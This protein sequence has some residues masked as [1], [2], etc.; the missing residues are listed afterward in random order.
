M[1]PTLTIYT[2]S[3]S[4]T[5]LNAI[6]NG[7]AAICNQSNYIWGFA[8]MAALFHLV[9]APMVTAIQGPSGHGG[10]VLTKAVTSPFVALLLA[11]LLTTPSLKGPVQI[12]STIN[13]KTAVVNN[14]PVVISIMPAAASLL[15][16]DLGTLVST[17]YQSAGTNY[18]ALSSQMNGFVNPLKALLGA[19]YVVMGLGHIDS[20]V[21]TVIDACLGS[22][23]GVDYASV[24]Q[25]VMN[26]GNTTGATAAQTTSI[27]GIQGTALGALMY[28]AS[29][30]AYGQVNNLDPNQ[31]IIYSCPDAVTKVNNDINTDL[32]SA[33]FSRAVQIGVNSMDQPLSTADF[34]LN[35]L[36]TQYNAL[37]NADSV[38]TANVYGAVQAQQEL[39][40][41]MFSSL[42][43]TDLSCLQANGSDKTTCYATMEQVQ[44]TER[45]N[46][47]AAAAETP[48][49]KYAGNLANY[50]LALIIGLGPILVLFM[51]L[52]GVDA[53]K[54]AKMAV[55]IMVWPLLV[56]NVGAE[57]INGMICIQLSDFYITL[58]Q[59]GVISQAETYTAYQELS[60][61]IGAAS[62]LMASLP[63]LMSMIFGLSATA[64]LVSVA[65]KNTPDFGKSAADLAPAPSVT[66]GHS[67]ASYDM[68]PDGSA[69]FSTT[70]S[71]R[72]IA[73]T[74]ELS[75]MQTAGS[76]LSSART[77]QHTVSEAKT[78]LAAWREAFTSGHYKG[79]TSDDSVGNE[80]RNAFNDLQRV[81]TNTT[82][83][84]QQQS[85][86]ANTNQSSA[87]AG[88]QGGL[89]VSTKPEGTGASA[90]GSVS[91]TTSTGASDSF[92]TTQNSARTQD[93]NQSR[94]LSTAIAKVMA[95]HTTSRS[96]QETRQELQRSMDIQSSYQDLMSK[97]D[98]NTSSA[99]AAV[100][101]S[102][103]FIQFQQ[104]IDPTTVSTQLA[105]NREFSAYETTAGMRFDADPSNR[106]YLNQAEQQINA[107]ETDTILGNDRAKHV[108]ARMRAATLLANDQKAPSEKRLA[109]LEYLVG[110][111]NAMFGRQVLTAKRPDAV[112]KFKDLH[113]PQD[114]TG[115]PKQPPAQPGHHKHHKGKDFHNTHVGTRVHHTPPIPHVGDNQK[116]LNAAGKALASDA[117]NITKTEVKQEIAASNAGL[118]QD[119]HGTARRTLNNA[120][121]NLHHQKGSG[122]NNEGKKVD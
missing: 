104:H 92:Q 80:I 8:V 106:Q 114:P 6:F 42:V 85:T 43:N 112:E 78:N 40:N 65:N 109:A 62:N 91:A 71:Q 1:W 69:H 111:A 90:S 81:S 58:R 11:F 117:T 21:K 19:R 86:Q 9:A 113:D 108:M 44:A 52:A 28:Q 47:Q 96:G 95:S 63:V 10:A 61:Q 73:S 101:D 76:A 98:T 48:M 77:A 119:G 72:A 2:A 27:N 74:A 38:N 56:M 16:N 12:E 5:L 20:E 25:L 93:Y 26:A 36:Q 118:G 7:V 39:Y 34:S 116:V 13:G 3:G 57:L 14:V 50:M 84:N 45:N 100:R 94:D 55:H 88:V 41:L 15:S 4:L 46:I 89:G 121:D 99:E 70:G 107:G 64:G 75:S 53:G 68:M 60:M 37:I 120:I 110:G 51:M 97:S 83:G 17:A 87:G 79:L 54:S 103:S 49:L 18:S 31:T 105:T 66:K 33:D 23:S 67:M 32:Q 102:Q 29:L 22:D 30:N 59:S 24:N 122:L 35:N 115:V 82:T